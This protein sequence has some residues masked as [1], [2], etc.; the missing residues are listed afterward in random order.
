MTDTDETWVPDRGV[1]PEDRVTPQLSDAAH[2][3]AGLRLCVR[4]AR[5]RMIERSHGEPF[6]P[7]VPSDL[8]NRQDL[9]SP[10]STRA[11]TSS[12]NTQ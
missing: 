6:S 4:A 8:A 3:F 5:L 10:S 7:T 12:P 9:Q 2:H 11:L 1:D